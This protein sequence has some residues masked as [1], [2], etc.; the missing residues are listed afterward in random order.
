MIAGRRHLG[1]IP[2]LENSPNA[3]LKNLDVND[4]CLDCLKLKNGE[5]EGQSKNCIVLKCV[6]RIEIE[7]S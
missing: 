2:Q 5:C 7:S 1:K 4:F 6:F 3:E